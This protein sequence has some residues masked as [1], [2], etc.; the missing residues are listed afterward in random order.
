MRLAQGGEPHQAHVQNT[1]QAYMRSLEF[2][3]DCHTEGVNYDKYHLYG[4]QPCYI[5]REGAL[6]LGTRFAE[7]VDGVALQRYSGR[8]CCTSSHAHNAAV[9]EL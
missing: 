3:I 4:H 1:F 7:V 6:A 5:D 2:P 9:D 8:M